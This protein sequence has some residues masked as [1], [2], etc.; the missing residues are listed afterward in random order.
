M[1]K[2]VCPKCGNNKSFYREISITAKLKVNNKEEDL[3]TIYDINKD[4]I[5]NYFEPIYCAKCNEIVKY[6][7]CLF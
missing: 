1:D 7:D 2:L 4:N 5:D 3:K 6:E